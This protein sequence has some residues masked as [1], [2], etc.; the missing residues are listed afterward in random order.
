MVMGVASRLADLRVDLRTDLRADLS[1]RMSASVAAGGRGAALV[2]KAAVGKAVSVLGAAYLER[3]LI[4][5]LNRDDDSGPR[6]EGWVV[7]ELR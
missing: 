1:A 6:D 3:L 4:L 2:L 5:W 7:G